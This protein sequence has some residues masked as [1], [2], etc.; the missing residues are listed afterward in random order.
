MPQTALVD[1]DYS[2]IDDARPKV[3]VVMNDNVDVGVILAHELIQIPFPNGDIPA[4]FA[5]SLALQ[6]L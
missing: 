2:S 4:W 3:F 6:L 1:V 5:P